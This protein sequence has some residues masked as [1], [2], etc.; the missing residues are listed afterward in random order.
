MDHQTRIPKQCQSRHK[1]GNSHQE[2][3]VVHG[4]GCHQY[5][6]VHGCERH[7]MFLRGRVLKLK[8]LVLACILSGQLKLDQLRMQR[9]PDF[10]Q[11]KFSLSFVCTL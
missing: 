8:V 7:Q 4:K 2:I 9:D 6:Y 10:I 1:I 11:G 5:M 3:V